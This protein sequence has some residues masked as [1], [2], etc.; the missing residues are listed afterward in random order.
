VLK[1]SAS[2]ELRRAIDSVLANKR[3]LSQNIEPEVR[4]A[5]EYEWFRP[6]GYSGELTGRQR[7]ILALLSEGRQQGR[8]R[9]NSISQ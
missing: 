1:Q 2:D 4:E 7:E 6:E 9:S 8:L 5:V 3:F